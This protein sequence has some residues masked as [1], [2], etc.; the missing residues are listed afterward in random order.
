M[1]KFKNHLPEYLMEGALLGLFMISAVLVTALFQH[2]DSPVHHLIPDPMIRRF[3]IGLAMGATAISLIYSPWGRRSGAHMNPAVTLTFL[4]L[5]KVKSIDAIFYVVFQFIGGALGVALTLALQGSVVSHP[6]VH[7]A[8]TVPGVWGAWP[9]FLA[10]FLM[11]GG[12][13]LTVLIVVSQPRLA[14]YT[15]YFAATLIVLYITFVAP[16]SGMS[17][18]PARTTASALWAGEWKHL[19][20]YFAAPIMGMMSGSLL[21]QLGWGLRQ[22][23]CAKLIHD[24]R[25]RCIFCGHPGVK[26][27]MKARDNRYPHSG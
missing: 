3:F 26:E 13:M 27:S 2:P 4:R 20:L 6:A 24:P 7:Y 1:N 5:G 25:V 17:L 15:G 10:E 9:A 12:M 16:V 8:V 18:N 22:L 19:W 21:Y 14:P 23:S 11:T